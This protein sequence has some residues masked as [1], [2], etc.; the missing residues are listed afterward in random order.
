MNGGWLYWLVEG[1][2]E[3]EGVY[4]GVNVCFLKCVWSNKVFSLSLKKDLKPN[5]EYLDLK[6]NNLPLP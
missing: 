6:K 2:R 4:A 1:E 3:G 5:T